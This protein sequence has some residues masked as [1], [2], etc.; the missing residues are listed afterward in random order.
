MH[1]LAVFWEKNGS[2]LV[3]KTE[4]STVFFVRFTTIFDEVCMKCV[5]I[6]GE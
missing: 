3:D 5:N 6:G 2:L 4:L 1:V